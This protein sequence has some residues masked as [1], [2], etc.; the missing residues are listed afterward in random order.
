M[1]SDRLFSTDC[2]GFDMSGN[3]ALA[4]ISIMAMA[5][6]INI[7]RNARTNDDFVLAVAFVFIPPVLFC[8]AVSH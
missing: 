6:G 3:I 2:R 8:W 7:G 5:F 1:R 4:L